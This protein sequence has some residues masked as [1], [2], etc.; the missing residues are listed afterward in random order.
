M[1]RFILRIA[2]LAAAILLID[3]ALGVAFHGLVRNAKGGETG[4]IDYICHKTTEDLL[5]FGS[6]RAAH[7]YDPRILEDS[8]GTSCYNCGKD[9]NGIIMLYGWYRIMR[10]RYRPRVIVYDIQPDYDLLEGDNAKFLPALRYFYD[11]DSIESIFW[12]VDG[13][14]RY[15]MALSAYRYNS[16]FLQIVLDNIKPAQQDIKGYRP[17]RGTMDYE[18]IVKENTPKVYAYDSLKLYYLKRLIL[19]CKQS[20][21]RLVFTASPQYK[22]ASS[23]VLAPIKEMCQ[24]YGLPFIDHFS[25]SAF[26]KEKRYFRDSAHL[27]EE[28]ATVYTR[29]VSQE[30]KHLTRTMI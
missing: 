8:L 30:I 18:P 12:K 28:G 14:E 23:E 22:N 24:K 5:V 15:K 17:L 3:A 1:K 2:A 26:N 20:G 29:T 16:Q 6:S 13:N 21:T 11:E 19:D 4:R 7:H 10:E 27:N 25:D 9:G